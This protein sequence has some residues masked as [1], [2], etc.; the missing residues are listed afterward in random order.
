MKSYLAAEEKETYSDHGEKD[1]N[2]IK[3]GFSRCD[4]RELLD[5]IQAIDGNIQ[6]GE[7]TIPPLRSLGFVCHDRG[8]RVVARKRCSVRAVGENPS[9]NG[10]V[11]PSC[12]RMPR[13]IGPF[14]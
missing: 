7:N 14:W 9:P 10:D 5:E 12:R 1:G 4:A 8:V 6:Q 13:A 3:S 2:R 11:R